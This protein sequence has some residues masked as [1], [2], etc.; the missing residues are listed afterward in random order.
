MAWARQF[1]DISKQDEETIIQTKKSLLFNEGIPWVKKGTNNFDIGQGSYDGAECAELVGLYLLSEVK[2][3]DRLNV[4]IYRDDGL[5]VSSASC[6]QNKNMSKKIAKIILTLQ[7]K[8][9]Q[10]E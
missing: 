3:I 10:K 8:Q 2:K 1:C 9:T 7:V 4:G 5:A 6:R